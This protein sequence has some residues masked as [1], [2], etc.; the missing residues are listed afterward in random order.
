MNWASGHLPQEVRPN[1]QPDEGSTARG[2]RS[3]LCVSWRYAS[4]LVIAITFQ[5][6]TFHSGPEALRELD[7][8]RHLLES[9]PNGV[10]ISSGTTRSKRDG[11][12]RV[13]RNRCGHDISF[14]VVGVLTDQ[15]HAPGSAKN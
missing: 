12:A 2:K 5:R 6:D 4:I 15:V 7:A 8:S 3:Q 1:R 13:Q 14:V 9:Q 11:D 10:A